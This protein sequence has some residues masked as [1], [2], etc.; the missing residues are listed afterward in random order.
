MKHH[1]SLQALNQTKLNPKHWYLWALSAMGIFLDGYDLFVISIALP[2]I[3]KEFTITPLLQGLIASAAVLG[4]IIGASLGGYISDKIGR[5]KVY[6]I[7]MALFVF[8]TILTAFSLNPYYLILFRFFLGVGIGADYPICASYISELMPASIRG[9]M[10]ISAFSFQA[11]GMLAAAIIGLFIITIYPNVDAWRYILASGSIMGLIVLILR[12]SISESPMW[13]LSQG[14]LKAAANAFANYS[15]LSREAIYKMLKAHPLSQEISNKNFELFHKKYRHQ[16][17]LASIPWFLMDIAFYGI[18]V[19]TPI[20]L[21]SLIHIQASG[22]IAAIYSSIAGAAF[23]DLFLVAG[24]IFN[25]IFVERIGRIRLQLIGFYGM[26]LGLFLILLHSFNENIQNHLGILFIFIG[27]SLFNLSMNIGP[28][29]TTFT[30]AAE[31]Y[32]TKI[33]ASGHGFA[34]SLGKVGAFIGIFFLPIITAKFGLSASLLFLCLFSALGAL[35]TFIFQIET[36][37]VELH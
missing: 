15:S 16:T 19:F 34:A 8:F 18:G 30:I 22:S 26:T 1:F 10:L 37:G 12:L 24:F 4:M 20:I 28:N 35:I 33:R 27:F 32:P 29:A 11:L 2:L 6:L 21:G 17:I 7:D 23:L 31:V 13:L 14:K 5:K 36:K 25:I 3:I 9:K